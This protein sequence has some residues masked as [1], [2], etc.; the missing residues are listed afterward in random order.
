MQG[1]RELDGR[2]RGRVCRSWSSTTTRPAR[3][4]AD[5]V[6]DRRHRRRGGA[7]AAE[8]R[9]GDRATSRPD[10]IVL[11]VGM[12]GIDGVTFAATL[13]A[14]RATREIGD[15]PAHRR[16]PARSRPDVTPAPRR[17]AQAVQP[18]R[19]ARRRRARVGGLSTAPLLA[20]ADERARGPAPPLRRRCPP[21]ARGRAAAPAQPRALV[22]RR[23]SARS[24]TRSSRGTSARART[25]AR[26]QRYARGADARARARAARRPE[27]SS[28]AICST[29][30]ARSASPIGSSSKPGPLDPR[31]APRD[32][33][34]T[35]PSARRSSPACG[36]LAGRG[37]R[38][39][40]ATTTS[41]GTARATPTGSQGDRDPVP[42]RASSPSPTRSTR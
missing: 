32:A 9:R 42:R 22:S 28:S 38:R 20:E 3:A 1:E 25:R 19:P 39:S 33:R 41:A 8:A 40:S 4:A 27:P 16:R 23:R 26:V 31:G 7:S 13:N 15:R 5:D 6:R 34:R 17:R 2:I 10:V 37:A 21:A 29:T 35:R 30:S 18:A 11:D 14:I 24:R 12:P 36:L